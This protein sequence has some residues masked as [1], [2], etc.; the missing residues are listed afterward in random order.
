MKLYFIRHADKGTGSCYNEHLQHQDYP[1]TK[2]GEKRAAKLA[3]YFEHINLDAVYAS[4]YKRAQQTAGAVA[5]RKGLSVSVDERLNEIDNGVIDGMS[6]EEIKRKYPVFFKDFL[7]FSKDVR[8]PG[9]ETGSETKQRQKSL[10][11]DLIKK[12]EDALLVTHEGYIRLLVCHLA[13]L[14]VYKRCKFKM[15]Y[16]GICEVEYLESSGQW[17]INKV[18]QTA[19][20]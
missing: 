1:I 10:L 5:E 16:C 3:E 6:D 7:S 17:R 2:Q 14:P 19:L 12:N 8:F 9:G 13:G 18:N 11:D 20:L 15:D 4:E